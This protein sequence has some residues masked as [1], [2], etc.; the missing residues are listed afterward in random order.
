MKKLRAWIDGFYGYRHLM[1]Q[2]VEKDIKMKY[3]RSFLGYLWSILNPLMIMIIMVAV[4]ST[5]FRFDILNYPVYLI[6]GQ[7]IFNFVSEATNQAMWSI[8]GNAALLKKTYVP[9]YIFTLSKVTS[10]CINTL[11]SLGALLIVCIVCKVRLNWYMLF[12]PVIMLQVY[13]FCVGLG[14]FLSQATVFFRDIQ[15]IYA[16]VITAWMYLTP[17][18]YPINQLP[19]ELMWGIKHF[20]PLYSYITQFRTIILEATMPDPRL[21]LYGFAVSFAML[22]IG[23]F[24]F[25]KNQDR[26]ILYI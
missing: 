19:F 5:M 15:Y 9:K 4:F 12:I 10:S 22:V 20:N 2:L 1:Q 16:A 17:I 3:R 23:T 8:T 13:V 6:T 26:F 18:F 25:F 14:M 24:C 11:F 7:T 21:V